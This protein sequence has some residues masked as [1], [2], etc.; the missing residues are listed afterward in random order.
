MPEQPTRHTLVVLRHAKSDWSTGHDDH[1]RPLADRG[2]RQAAEAG[3]WLAGSGPD[4]DLVVRSPATRA[5]STWD[6]VAAQLSTVP[7]VRVDDR[8]YA[9]SLDDLLT[10]LAELPEDA[11]TTVLVGHNPGLEELVEH[12]TG[13]PVRMPT[14]AVAVVDVPGRWSGVADVVCALRTSGR[15]PS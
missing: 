2:R 6:L 13:E 14:S 15:P 10:V 11:A 9:A 4:L 3:R 7:A 5:G 12:L 8:V 1:D